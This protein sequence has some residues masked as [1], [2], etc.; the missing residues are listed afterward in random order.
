MAGISNHLRVSVARQRALIWMVQQLRTSR[1]HMLV[2]SF[3]LE[4]LP[5]RWLLSSLF[6]YNL[7]C[8]PVSNV[9]LTLPP[10]Q[11]Y[12]FPCYLRANVANPELL[13]KSD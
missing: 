5:V 6:E 7:T 2:S 4:Q 11:W 1:P 12:N 13:V 8:F 9:S 3:F 10:S